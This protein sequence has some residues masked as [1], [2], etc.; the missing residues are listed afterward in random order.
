MNHYSITDYGKMISGPSRVRYDSYETALKRAITADS[1]VLD[2]GTGAGVFAILA[3]KLG[4]KRVYAVESSDVIEVAE[5]MANDNALLD[6]VVLIQGLSTEISLPEKVDV[7]ISDLRGTLPLFRNNISSIIDAR[8][9]FLKPGGQL[10]P[11]RDQLMIA[12]VSAPQ[13][14]QDLLEPWSSADLNLS[15]GRDRALNEP[16][17]FIAKDYQLAAEA[18]ILGK[19]DYRT[20]VSPDFS[21]KV[22]FATINQSEIHGFCLW[23]NAELLE[24][25]GYSNHPDSPPLV[26]AQIFLPLLEPVRGAS[27]IE[28]EFDAVFIED[29]YVYRW[30]TV[31]RDASQRELARFSQSTFFASL[32][33]AKTQA[34]LKT[35]LALT[36]HRG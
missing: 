11:E 20:I 32:I 26:Y 27:T 19:I 36:D 29:D 28:V 24:G 17:R 4:A 31:A 13:L 1:T 23:F 15:T 6:R 9:R 5:Q 25:I 2:I 35:R 14:Y 3:C 7:I 16:S 12:P 21:G 8:C 10:I 33:G 34:E 22:E 18:K 30:T